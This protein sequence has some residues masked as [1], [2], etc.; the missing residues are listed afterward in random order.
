LHKKIT[1]KNNIVITLSWAAFTLWLL[2]YW[3]KKGDKLFDK[4]FT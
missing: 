2:I 4:Y 3:R 1:G